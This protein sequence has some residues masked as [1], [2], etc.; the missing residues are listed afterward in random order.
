MLCGHI[1]TDPLT[2]YAPATGPCWASHAPI[3]T[4]CTLAAVGTLGWQENRYFYGPFCWPVAR[5]AGE[6]VHVT[7]PLLRHTLSI[8]MCSVCPMSCDYWNHS[9]ENLLCTTWGCKGQP[10][11]L[12]SGLVLTDLWH[13]A[14][15]WSPLAGKLCLAYCFQRL[16]YIFSTLL[17]PLALLPSVSFWADD[18]FLW[19]YWESWDI[20]WKFPFPFFCISNSPFLISVSFWP[21]NFLQIFGHCPA[22]AGHTVRW[23]GCIV[24]VKK[25][26]TA[27]FHLETAG[28]GRR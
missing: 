27:L 20:Q 28:P 8:P 24:W 23:W 19:L 18:I 9:S 5:V 6:D 12:S 21:P 17:N 26:K 16:F 11:P 3:T 10:G 15:L 1:H 13:M 2:T 22:Y 7:Q 25:K 4:G 14:L